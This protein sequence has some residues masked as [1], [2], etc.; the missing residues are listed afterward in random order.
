MGLLSL[1]C[2]ILG[3]EGAEE[4]L[5]RMVAVVA[6]GNCDAHIKNW[7]LVYPNRVRAAWSPLYDQVATIAYPDLDERLAL[8]IGTA[9]YLH[10]VDRDNIQWVGNKIGL[11]AQRCDELIDSTLTELQGAFSGVE[12]PEELGPVRQTLKR[13]RGRAR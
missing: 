13:S 7:S 6:L 5:R 8:R 2:Q 11:G 10:Q 4:G 3:A 9:K 12:M 1:A